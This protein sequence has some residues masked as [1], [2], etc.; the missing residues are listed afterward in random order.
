MSNF[1]MDEFIYDKEQQEVMDLLL[2]TKLAKENCK[3]YKLINL[4]TKAKIPT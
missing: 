3:G 2:D 4:H 1:N